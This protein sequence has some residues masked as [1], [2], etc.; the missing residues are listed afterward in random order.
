MATYL[1]PY[2]ILGKNIRRGGMR[3]PELAELL[4]MEQL[5]ARLQHLAFLFGVKIKS[6]ARL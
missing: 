3:F 4:F 5:E 1:I 2:R 6:F